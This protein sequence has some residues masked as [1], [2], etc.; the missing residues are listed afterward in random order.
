MKLSDLLTDSQGR[1]EAKAV[2][3]WALV[4]V[5][6]V[7]LLIRGDV[8]GFLGIEAAAGGFFT[9]KT[10][11]DAKLDKLAVLSKLAPT[12]EAGAGGQ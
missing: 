2:I 7:Y 5:G 8:P 11:E 10:V 1:L 6:I 3:G 4:V 9:A 12:S